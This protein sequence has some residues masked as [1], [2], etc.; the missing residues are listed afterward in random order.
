MSEMMD[1]NVG[2]DDG[3]SEAN[4][5]AES[6][7]EQLA[8]QAESRRFTPLWVRPSG[9]ELDMEK[10]KQWGQKL[11]HHFLRRSE[12][13]G[14]DV[15][16][17]LGIVYKPDMAPPDQHWPLEVGL[18]RGRCLPLQGGPTHQ[19]FGAEINSPCPW[20]EGEELGEL[21]PAISAS[22][23]FADLLGCPDERSKLQQEA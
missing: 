9:Q 15:R 10:V 19:R 23:R 6:E 16:L 22:E 13:R 12:Y 1:S 21:Q 2:A 11:V 3:E 4:H 7:S 8:L 20:M 17:D 18:E 5:D 14:S